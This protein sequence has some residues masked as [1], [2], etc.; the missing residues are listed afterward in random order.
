[1]NGPLTLFVR[2]VALSRRAR[3]LVESVVVV[4]DDAVGG[5][6]GGSSVISPLRFELDI[7]VSILVS[8]AFLAAVGG[9]GGGRVE[10]FGIDCEDAG[11]DIDCSI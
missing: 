11:G 6:G 3:T 8:L 1:M 2:L 5:G 10:V 9:G 4:V 7:G